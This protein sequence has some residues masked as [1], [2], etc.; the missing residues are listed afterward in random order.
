MEFFMEEDYSHL[1]LA[2]FGKYADTSNMRCILSLS[3]GNY[4]AT[5]NDKVI[6]S[7]EF[8]NSRH[9]HIHEYCHHFANPLAEKWYEE[10]KTFQ[11]WC[12]TSVDRKKLPMYDSGI[13]MAREYVT[14]AYTILYFVQHSDFSR[15]EEAGFTSIEQVMNE[16]FSRERVGF[17]YIEQVYDMILAL[18]K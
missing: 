11:K 18:E 4:G 5:V 13:T 17:T 8:V 12:D 3:S 7:L 2:W 14:R 16:Y 15:I 10:N 1:D 6:Y 9:A